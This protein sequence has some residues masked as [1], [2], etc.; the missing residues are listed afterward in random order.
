M[1]T[2]STTCGTN[3]IV[4]LSPMCPPDSH[5]SAITAAAPHLCIRFASATE[6]TTGITFISASNHAFMYGSGVPAPVVTTGTFSST[7]TFAISGAAGFKSITFTP[8]GL[9]VSPLVF[10]LSSRT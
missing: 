4:V 8:N 10:L 5:P 1:S 2:A 6:A 7:K 3:V 9:S